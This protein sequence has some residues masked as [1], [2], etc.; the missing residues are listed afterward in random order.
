MQVEDLQQA[1][2]DIPDGVHGA[3]K[4]QRVIYRQELVSV[5]F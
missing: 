5:S 3:R 4:P 1:I 2:E